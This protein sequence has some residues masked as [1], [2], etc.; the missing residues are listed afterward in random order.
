MNLHQAQTFLGQSEVEE[1]AA[2]LDEFLCSWNWWINL[3]CE[4]NNKK[5]IQNGKGTNQFSFLF[6]KLSIYRNFYLDLIS[7]ALQRKL[8][9][10]SSH[11]NLHLCFVSFPLTC[12]DDDDNPEQR[13]IKF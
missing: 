5:L 1:E 6:M 7:F 8:K 3:K 9:D 13:E 2:C 12:D 11:G 10:D 4:V